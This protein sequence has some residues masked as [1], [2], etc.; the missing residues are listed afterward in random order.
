MKKPHLLLIAFPLLLA[1]PVA[2][3]AVV[4][5]S[6]AAITTTTNSSKFLDVTPNNDIV[7]VEAPIV[8][9]AG[10]YTL[11]IDANFSVKPQNGLGLR[12]DSIGG[13][14]DTTIWNVNSV[15]V[16]EW[17]TY[18]VDFTVNATGDNNGGI[19]F[20]LANT[21]AQGDQ[22]PFLVDN[23]FITGDGGGADFDEDFESYMVGDP[24]SATNVQLQGSSGIVA[25]VPEPSSAMLLAS[26]GLLGLLRRR[27]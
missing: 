15:N 18:T 10:S 4:S 23:Y 8:L 19:E 3:A 1:A 6:N 16:N 27:R 12:F 2:S 26:V 22:S 9:V 25:A 5:I 11:S 20:R 24:A 17:N 21:N 7:Q 13:N 14:D